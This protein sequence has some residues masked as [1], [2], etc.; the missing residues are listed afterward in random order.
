MKKLSL[1][2]GLSVC[3]SQLAFGYQ[4]NPEKIYKALKVKETV[5]NPGIVG[6]SRTE[7][8]VGGLICEKSV[9]IVPNAKPTYSCRTDDSQA[10]FE[11][12]YKAMDVKE[13]TL[14]PGI[15]GSSRKMKVAGGLVCI[16]SVIVVPNAKPQYECEIDV[17]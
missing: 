15:V 14:N 16:R 5:L 12:I 1:I 7:K 4:Y 11:A 8:S 3:M 2:L 6:S 17:E 13:K 9:I 10:N